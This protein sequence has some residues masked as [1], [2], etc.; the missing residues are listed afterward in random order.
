MLVLAY[1]TNQLN[2]FKDTLSFLVQPVYEVVNFPSTVSKWITQSSTDRAELL[3]ENRLLKSEALFLKAKLQKFDAIEQENNRLHSLLESS[4][5][6]GEQFISASLINVNQNP[7]TQHV[8]IDKGRRFDL[9][10][11]QA[12]L[13]EDGII[14]Q[15]IDV[16]PLTSSIMLITDPNHAIPIEINRTGLRT[17]ATGNG[18]K[19][20]LIL[21]YL[22][23]NADIKTGDLL[24]T[25]GLGGVF[26]KGYPVGVVSKLTPL[27]GEAFMYAEAQTVAKIDSTHE[28]LL[29]W[30]KQQPISLLE[31]APAAKPEH[32]TPRAR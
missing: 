30:S 13:N 18:S 31:G 28:V 32:I 21:P 10:Q 29:V 5:K 2:R 7:N 14:G 19:N 1:K 11:S 25:S 16:R 24:T 15:I 6:I 27:S 22:P 8:V 23:H 12:A 20:I 9:Y 4:F 3:E 17:I 26:P